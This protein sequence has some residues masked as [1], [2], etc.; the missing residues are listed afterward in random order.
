MTQNSKTKIYSTGPGWV[1]LEEPGQEPRE[2]QVPNYSGLHYV[3]EWWRGD[4]RPV[5]RGLG[6]TG[7]SLVATT[8][9]LLSVIRKAH[10][11]RLRRTWRVRV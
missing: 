2:F 7:A 9:G 11:A 1:V 5:S 4:Y 6:P 10:A 8:D 3:R